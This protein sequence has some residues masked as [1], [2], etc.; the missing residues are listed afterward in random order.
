[1]QATTLLAAAVHRC[2]RPQ[3]PQY[4]TIGIVFAALDFIVMLGYA[5]VGAHAIRLLRRRAV[6]W[7]DRC[8][9]GALLA[10]SGSLVLYR[11]T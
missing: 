6:V 10:L 11:R 5:A 8:C 4:V 1:M 2:R 9:G 7:L 3:W